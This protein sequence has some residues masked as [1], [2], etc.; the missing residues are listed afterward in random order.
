MKRRLNQKVLFE[1]TAA[2]LRHWLIEHGEELAGKKFEIKQVERSLQE[3][4][5]RRS[6]AER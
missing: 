3:V 4:P 6:V 1:G 2:E 5:L